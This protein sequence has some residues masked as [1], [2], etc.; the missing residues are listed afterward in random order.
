MLEKFLVTLNFDIINQIDKYIETNNKAIPINDEVD[1]SVAI[2]I[3]R[4]PKYRKIETEII[5]GN[6]R[7]V[8]IKCFNTL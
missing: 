8:S 4:N 1:R 6:W 7:V 2:K 3:A 5:I